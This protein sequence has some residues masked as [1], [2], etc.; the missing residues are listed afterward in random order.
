MQCHFYLFLFSHHRI[1]YYLLHWKQGWLTSFWALQT[2]TEK[3]NGRY[4][5]K[6][7]Y[8]FRYIMYGIHFFFSK[9]HV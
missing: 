6:V 8:W 7:K 5:I 3:E 1:L 9:F 4:Y 2:Q